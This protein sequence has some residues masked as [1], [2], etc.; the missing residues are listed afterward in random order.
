MP[1]TDYYHTLKVPRTASQDQIRQAF[2]RLARE[3]HPDLNKSPLAESRFKTINEAYETLGDPTRRAEYDEEHL[4]LRREGV[5]HHRPTNSHPRGKSQWGEAAD[6]AGFGKNPTPNKE[7]TAS[8]SQP[9]RNP[10]SFDS[11]GS[12]EGKTFHQEKFSRTT[13]KTFQNGQ[14]KPPER[15]Q[16]P[17]EIR[18]ALTLEEAAS[19]GEHDISINLPELGG[20]RTYQVK[21]P[22]ASMPGQKIRIKGPSGH[23]CEQHLDLVVEHLPHSRFRMEGR[24]LYL[25]LPVS[26][27]EAALGARIEVTTLTCRLVAHIPSSSS[28]GRKIMLRG[29]GFPARLGEQPGDLYLELRIVTPSKLSDDETRLFTKLANTSS[30]NPRA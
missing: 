20:L 8:S 30:F 1:P 21:V 10:F 25:I 4:A 22:P 13:F 26:P 24:D 28:S 19:G 18:L 17:L 2:R 9:G 6:F 15:E 23:R 29:Q 11:K 7:G 5:M 27:W 12:G 14:K 3:Y 16:E